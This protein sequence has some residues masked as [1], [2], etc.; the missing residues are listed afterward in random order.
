MNV[1]YTLI[2]AHAPSEISL[3]KTISRTE[4]VKRLPAGIV[5]WERVREGL[6]SSRQRYFEMT[7]IH[8]N[9]T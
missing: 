7:S 3:L 4:R 9:C 1:L 8:G 2:G 5:M 6:P